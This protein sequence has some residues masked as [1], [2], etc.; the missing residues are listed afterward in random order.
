M[1]YKAFIRKYMKDNRISYADLASVM[2]TTRQNV[3]A[4]LNKKDG[5]LSLTTL[6]KICKALGLEMSDIL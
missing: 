3:W 4:I 5:N 2:G 1:D 6:E